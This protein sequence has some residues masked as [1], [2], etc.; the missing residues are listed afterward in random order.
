MATGTVKW[1]N[2]TKQP[3]AGGADVFVLI[4][5]FLKGF[6]AVGGTENAAFGVGA[7]GMALGG[8]ENTVGIFG[9]DEDRGDLLGVAEIFEMRPR[10]SGVGGFVDAVARGKIGA[11][12]SFAAADVNDVG[13]GRRNGESTDGAGGLIVE[14]GIPGVAEVG[15]LPDAAVDGRHVENVGLVRNAADGDGAA[16]TEGADAAP[17]H[18]G[19]ELRVVLLG[20]RWETRPETDENREKRF[21]DEA[22][23][24]RMTSH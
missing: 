6:A 14:D 22:L 13:V 24:C 20:F 4:E 5:N 17:A 2:A 21:E 3:D 1:F 19:E 9:I 10:F 12:Q 7:V 16:S 15:G 18:F 11:L 23:P 8:D